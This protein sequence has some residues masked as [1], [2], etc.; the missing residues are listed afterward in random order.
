MKIFISHSSKE[1]ELAKE[2][3]AFL[4]KL[5][6][7]T[8]VFCSSESGSIGVGEDYVERVENELDACD[9]F[10]PL[11]STNYYKS[12]FCMVELGFAFCLL[13]NKR[14]NDKRVFIYPLAVAPVRKGTALEGTPLSRLQSAAVHSPED[15]RWFVGEI[16]PGFEAVSEIESFIQQVNRIMGRAYQGLEKA[17]ILLC[18]SGDVP[19]EDGDYLTCSKCAQG[20]GYAVH[21]T[22]KP[23]SNSDK[24]P[25]FLSTVFK[26][27][28]YLDL[29]NMVTLFGEAK[30]K[31]R[32]N[33]LTNS[34]R[35]LGF[36]IK[37]SGTEILT[38]KE[39]ELR[40]GMNE[41]A[42]P[43]GEFPYEK[44]QYVSEICFVISPSAYLEDEGS[45]EIRNLRLEEQ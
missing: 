31:F 25:G 33:N 17:E 30:I 8:S 40:E 28:D 4:T 5:D 38:K 29:Y 18:K 44:L 36:E 42:I 14:E 3:S 37:H 19:G 23:F 39:L 26:Y 10:I 34:I 43:L 21:F 7:A 16:Y 41:F 35:K 24:Y 2:L 1:A 11:L 12:H 20:D 9:I 13:R 15:M 22:S 6:D 32:I 45:F 27:V